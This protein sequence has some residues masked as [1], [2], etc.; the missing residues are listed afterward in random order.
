MTLAYQMEAALSANKYIYHVDVT[1]LCRR[2]KWWMCFKKPANAL[3]ISDA[4]KLYC[5]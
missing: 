4:I 3:D 5:R 2:I 1:L